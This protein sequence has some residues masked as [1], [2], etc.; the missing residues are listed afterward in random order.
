M[1]VDRG[2]HGSGRVG[3]VPDPEPTRIFR[4]GKIR[5]RNR[6]VLMVGS[7]GSGSSGFGL[8]RFS[9]GFRCQFRYFASDVDISPDRSR[10]GRYLAGFV[11]SGVDLTGS[12]RIW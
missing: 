11:E 10:S 1:V 5:N 8:C 3:F 4:V 7:F 9:F 6:P 2:V 12:R